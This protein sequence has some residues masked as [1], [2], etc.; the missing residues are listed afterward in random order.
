MGRKT[1]IA[2]TA[3]ALLVP[4][5]VFLPSAG[6]QQ[7]TGVPGSPSSTITLDGSQLPPPPTKFGGVI[8]ETYLKSKPY[9]PPQV[10]PPKGA[11]T[12]C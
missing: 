10:V 8:N 9:W 2:A 12:F 6:G 4:T 11:P 3:A 7:V 1:V 5:L